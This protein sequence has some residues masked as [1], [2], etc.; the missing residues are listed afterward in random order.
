AEATVVPISLVPPSISLD[1]LVSTGLGNRPELAESQSLV[2]AA[3]ARYRQARLDPLI[4]K[5]EVSYFGGT[6]G[7]GINSEMKNFSGRSD[8][9]AQAVWELRNLGA[10]NIAQTR[11]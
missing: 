4:P 1:Q 7:G 10:G 2:M 6:F 9:T 3:Q 11:V 5:L 8:G